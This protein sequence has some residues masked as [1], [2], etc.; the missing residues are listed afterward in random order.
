MAETA[1]T[2]PQHKNATEHSMTEEQAIGQFLAGHLHGRDTDKV[3][4]ILENLITWTMMASY[5]FDKRNAARACDALCENAKAMIDAV[6]VP[7]HAS[8]AQQ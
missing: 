8:V 1:W 6:E 2:N 5:K 7:A 3:F 4:L